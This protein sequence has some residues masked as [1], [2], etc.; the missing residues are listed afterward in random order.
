V[1]RNAAH[2]APAAAKSGP[3]QR[4]PISTFAASDRFGHDFDRIAVHSPQNISRVSA[5]VIQR[6]PDDAEWEISPDPVEEPAKAVTEHSSRMIVAFNSDR[7]KR[8]MTVPRLLKLMKPYLMDRRARFLFAGLVPDDAKD[9]DAAKDRAYKRADLWRQAVIAMIDTRRWPEHYFR[10]GFASGTKRDPQVEVWV[11]Y[12]P[13]VLSKGTS[14]GFGAYDPQPGP[15]SPGVSADFKPPL[16]VLLKYGES[17]VLKVAIPKEARLATPP[18]GGT[19]EIVI[20]ASGSLNDLMKLLKPAETATE[21]QAPGTTPAVEPGPPVSAAFSL[22][23]K[24]GANVG[25]TL[26]A[27][28]NFE[29]RQVSTGLSFLVTTPTGMCVVPSGAMR[30][31]A[32]AVRKLDELGVTSRVEP[33]RTPLAQDPLAPGPVEPSPE[34]GPPSV[35]VEEIPET[36]ITLAEA[37][38]AIVSQLTAIDDAKAQCEKGK[39]AKVE[40]G[41]SASVFTGEQEPSAP[42]P[43]SIGFT[44]KLF[45]D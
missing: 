27:T 2:G 36:A 5:P 29:A 26:S 43:P 16:T 4:A 19:N 34:A 40:V 20:S 7:K 39:K 28:Y 1:H 21:E 25:T 30:A 44:L 3:A 22:S 42:Q 23:V 14:I 31:I 35:E 41:A 17:E 37:A 18:L 33:A 45:F 32:D 13:V 24:A 6:Q 8:N 15:S 38:A 10:I 12:A 9:R 11:Q